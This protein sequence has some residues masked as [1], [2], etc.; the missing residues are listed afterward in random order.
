MAREILSKSCKL[1]SI[2]SKLSCLNSYQ[3]NANV[4]NM[5][6]K[7]G[8]EFGAD[9]ASKTG[10]EFDVDLASKSGFG[11]AVDFASKTGLIF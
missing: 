3:R 8:F 11:F 9:L 6:S 1:S 7:T 5:I 4:T 2:L 10:F